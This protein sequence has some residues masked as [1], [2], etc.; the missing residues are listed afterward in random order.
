MC[1]LKAVVVA[2]LI[3]A[4]GIVDIESASAADNFPGGMNPVGTQPIAD[5]VPAAYTP[6]PIYTPPVNSYPPYGGPALPAASMPE[7]LQASAPITSLPTPQPAIPA[8]GSY[9]D[10]N[11]QK[12]ATPTVIR[13][14]VPVP[15]VD[16]RVLES[17]WYTKIEYFHWNEQIGGENLVNETG[18]LFTLGYQRRVGCERFRAELFGSQVDYSGGYLDNMGDFHPLDSVTNYL[19]VRGEYDLLLEPETL[20][21]V[22]FFVGLGTRIWNRDLPETS[23]TVAT[24]ED[25]FTFYPYVGIERRRKV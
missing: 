15:A 25:W 14:E 23:V 4:A 3:V 10:P 9:S 5:V 8:P 19:G 20:P 18:P 24:Q 17:T 13:E 22:S 16:N 21:D 1:V 2:T 12:Y 7:M 11:W 6:L